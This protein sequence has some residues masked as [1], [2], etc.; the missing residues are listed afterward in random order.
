MRYI[1]YRRISKS[2]KSSEIQKFFDELIKNGEE[3]IYYNETCVN[4]LIS[5]NAVLGKL[6]LENIL[7]ENG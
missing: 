7:S 5:V 3:I 2:F 1:K 6:R 4:D